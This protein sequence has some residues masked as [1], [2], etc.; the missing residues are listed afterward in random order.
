SHITDVGTLSGSD[1]WDPGSI[2]VGAMEAKD[3]TVTGAALGDSAIASF[4]LDLTDLV[5]N[6][7][8]TA[9]NTVTCVLVNN[10]AG[11][12]DLGSGTIYAKII[13]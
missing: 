8:V 7:Q 5:L 4:S 10:T 11:A 13:K 6:A 9:A 3:V 12:V 1:T 2:A